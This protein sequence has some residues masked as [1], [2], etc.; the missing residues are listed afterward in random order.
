M[1]YPELTLCA[2]LLAPLFSSPS[3]EISAGETR[4]TAAI[5]EESGQVVLREGETPI[6]QYN[7]RRVEVPAGM[8]DVE[9]PETLAY[10]QRYAKPRSNYIH[11]LYGLDGESLTLDWSPDH[12][13]HRGI[14]WAWPEVGLVDSSGQPNTSDLHALVGIFARP[15]GQ[16]ILD[17]SD[18]AASVTMRN[19]WLWRDEEPAVFERVRITAQALDDDGVRSI[20]LELRFEALRDGVTL[21]RR[22]TNLYGGLNTRLAKVAEQETEYHADPEGADPR[23]A[24]SCLRGTWSG[25]R[26]LTTLAILDDPN[27]PDYPGDWIEYPELPWFQPAFPRADS[28]FSLRRGEPLV[29]RYRYLVI[30]GAATPSIL[31]SAWDAFASD[32]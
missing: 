4:M 31:D 18:D 14:Y 12:P 29:L 1:I 8:F 23:R 20:D 27:N 25:G 5:D 10:R 28:R 11:P 9:N 30:P 21:A 32:H 19:L 2:A 26:R 7:A 6:L 22:G 17:S 16:P 15:V 24:W 3:S 13:H